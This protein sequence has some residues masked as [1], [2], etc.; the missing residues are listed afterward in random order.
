MTKLRHEYS[1]EQ[2]ANIDHVD[3]SLDITTT[4]GAVPEPAEWILIG[5]CICGIVALK[6]KPQMVGLRIFNK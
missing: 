4:S 5:I 3:W 1:P 6:L 2:I